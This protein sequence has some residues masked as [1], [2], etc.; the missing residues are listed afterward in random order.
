MSDTEIF[1][2]DEP[3]LEVE[4]KEPEPAPV[5]EK[6]EKPKKKFVKIS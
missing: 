5:T 4:T 3:K 6:P 1:V 2:Q